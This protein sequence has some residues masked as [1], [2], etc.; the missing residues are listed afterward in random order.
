MEIQ[1]KPLQ[2]G[3]EYS[4][5]GEDSI[6]QEMVNEMQAQMERMYAEKKMK[7]QI[8]TKM[9]G[10]V[11]A[12]FTIQDNL[13]KELQVGVFKIAKSFHAYIRFSNSQT[14]PKPDKKKDIR[15]IAIKLLNV[16]GEKVLNDKKDGNTQDFLLMSSETFFSKNISEFRKTLKASTAKSKSKLLFYF[17]NPKHWSLLKRLIKTFVKCD[18]PLSIE[19]WSTQ[20]Y[21]FGNKYKAVKYYLKPSPENQ[22]INENIKDDNYLRAN[23][24]QTLH[25]NTAKFDFFIQFQTNAD[26][27]PIEDPTIPWDSEFIKVATL[28]IPSQDFNTEDMDDFGEK[29]SFN[30]W[31]TLTEHRP[32]GNFNRARKRV[33]ETMYAFRQAYN[34]VPEVKPT[35]SPNFLENTSWPKHNNIPHQIPT[36]KSV[37]TMAQVEMDCSKKTAFEF[38]SNS[39]ELPRWL[40]KYGNIHAALNTEILSESYDFIGAKRKVYFNGGDSTIEELLTYNPHANYSYKIYD[41]TNAIKKFTDAGFG[42]FWFDRVGNKTRVTWVYTFSYKNIFS[43]IIL[44]L[45][46]KFV[47]KKFM[48][49]NLVN[50]KNYIENG[51]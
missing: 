39:D 42:Q 17:L 13:P 47:F 21:R 33:Y 46:L 28:N 23:L 22:V 50:A 7:R 27:M 8:H 12:K 44:K 51:D 18:N 30:S 10:C 19:Y 11:K 37:K 31:H 16:P 32:L 48:Y 9:H 34:K 29:L 43:K 20:P 1:K 45:L 2:I 5:A 35:D 49:N 14:E 38:I 4:S 41:F 26:S 36:K 24:S 6:I 25:S 40:K 3:H 15:G